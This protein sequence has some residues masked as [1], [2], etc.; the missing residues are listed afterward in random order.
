[1][2]SYFELIPQELIEIIFSRLNRDEVESIFQEFKNVPSPNSINMMKMNYP[3]W[4]KALNLKNTMEYVDDPN[5][6]TGYLDTFWEDYW[7][8]ARIAERY[9]EVKEYMK[10]GKFVCGY[11]NLTNF[12]NTYVD[13]YRIDMYDKGHLYEIFFDILFKCFKILNDKLKNIGINLTSEESKTFNLLVFYFIGD[14][15]SNYYNE[16]FDSITK[17]TSFDINSLPFEQ[18]DEEEY[19]DLHNGFTNY[20]NLVDLEYHDTLSFD[21][22]FGLFLRLIYEDAIKNNVRINRNVFT[23]FDEHM[24]H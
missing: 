5:W 16:Y 18:F 20:M 24:H 1:M 21:K 10:Y 4:T 14:R 9:P 3:Y 13:G 7:N 8:W 12:Y 22:A 6:F 17:G 23:I 19:E 11:I 2:E 15:Y